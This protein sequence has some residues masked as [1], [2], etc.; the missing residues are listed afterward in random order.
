MGRNYIDYI[1]SEPMTRQQAKAALQFAV[2][3]LRKLDKKRQYKKT[4]AIQVTLNAN[5][6]FPVFRAA[7]NQAAKIEMPWATLYFN[8]I[9]VRKRAR[10]S[11]DTEPCVFEVGVA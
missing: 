2:E 1:P 7:F 4:A 3:F 10:G 6:H 9:G 5:E 11:E 8:V